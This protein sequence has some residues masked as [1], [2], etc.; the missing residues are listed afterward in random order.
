MIAPEE[1]STRLT[2]SWSVEHLERLRESLESEVDTD[3]AREAGEAIEIIL[4]IPAAEVKAR[5]SEL[6]R[7]EADLQAREAT[8][9]ARGQHGPGTQTFLPLVVLAMVVA[10]AVTWL[11]RSNSTGAV[12]DVALVLIGV[13]MPVAYWLVRRL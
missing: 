7:A 2:Q 3:V 10:L 6:Q 5:V 11:V 12:H 4:R 13:S 1:S 8:I 9:N